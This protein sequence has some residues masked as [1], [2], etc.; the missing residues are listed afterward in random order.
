MILLEQTVLSRLAKLSAG[1]NQ[2]RNSHDLSLRVPVSGKDELAQLG[3][4][5]NEMLAA[6]E[7]SEEAERQQRLIRRDAAPDG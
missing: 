2:I 3:H 4:A 6:L 5:V 1:V 7:Q